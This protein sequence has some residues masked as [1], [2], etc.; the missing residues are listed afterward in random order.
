[1]KSNSAVMTLRSQLPPAPESVGQARHL[2]ADLLAEA[3]RTDV[4]D[5]VTLL[6]S[7]TIT[8]AVLYART[9]IGVSCE[10]RPDRVRVEVTDQSPADPDLSSHDREWATGC[11]LTMVDLM[12]ASWGVY[13]TTTGKAVWFEI[14]ED[15]VPV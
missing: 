11:G 3:D 13:A 4:T 1:M 14:A 15:D 5:T 9:A 7:E 6:A 2:I 12:A 10:V 8:N